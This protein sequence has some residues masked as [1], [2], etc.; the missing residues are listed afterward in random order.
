M[1]YVID[2][3]RNLLFWID[4]NNPEMVAKKAATIS[5]VAEVIIVTGQPKYEM[6]NTDDG[7]RLTKATAS[8]TIRFFVSKGGIAAL[9]AFLTDL[10]T[11]MGQ[12]EEIALRKLTRDEE[13]IETTEAQPDPESDTV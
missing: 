9:V 12:L 6:T 13:V 5:P 7:S 3:S 1:N 4:T 11:E 2:C 10:N 8:E